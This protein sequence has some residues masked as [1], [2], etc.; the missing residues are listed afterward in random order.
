MCLPALP[1]LLSAAL[2]TRARERRAL[3]ILILREDGN[4]LHQM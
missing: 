3:T 1:Q 2:A 4:N